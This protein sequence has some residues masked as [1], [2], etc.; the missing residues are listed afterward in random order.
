MPPLPGEPPPEPLAEP[1]A[2]PA[3][4]RHRER[5]TALGLCEVRVVQRGDSL[6]PQL[7]QPYHGAPCP[8]LYGSPK[9]KENQVLS[10]HNP[11][12]ISNQLQFVDDTQL[13]ALE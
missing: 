6:M 4:R 8:R 10:Y 1:K 5:S 7:L 13:R 11:I 9:D 2:A 12:L 3:I